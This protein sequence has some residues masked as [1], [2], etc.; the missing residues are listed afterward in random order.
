VQSVLALVIAAAATLGFVAFAGGAVLWARA[1]ALGLPPDLIVSIIPRTELVATGASS[2]TGFVL[3]G[4]LA[5]GFVYILDPHGLASRGTRIG[6]VALVAVEVAVAVYYVQPSRDEWV[7]MALLTIAALGGILWV[8]EHFSHKTRVSGGRGASAGVAQEVTGA[9]EALTLGV[10][11]VALLLTW[12]IFHILWLVVA[13]GVAFALYVVTVAVARGTGSSF[14]PTGAAVFASAVIYGAA[15]SGLH[16]TASRQVQ[17]IA[18]LRNGE[19]APVCGV[20]VAE[21]GDRLYMARLDRDRKH[22][23]S[24]GDVFW[25]DRKAVDGWALANLQ[26]RSDADA[27]LS[28][29]S[30]RL[31]EDRRTQITH[32]H[33]EVRHEKQAGEKTA[34][35]HSGRRTIALAPAADPHAPPCSIYADRAAGG[36]AGAKTR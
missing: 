12:L 35:L 2:L 19:A 21:A 18:A 36:T 1:Y 15:M 20:F 31:L 8:A 23:G 29:L 11:A 17:P 16:Y 25:L 13:V 22:G 3:L 6:L 30:A 10:I 33:T 5:V 26:G 4:I 34:V 24:A 9:G 28:T 14:G 27:A 32:T 7:W